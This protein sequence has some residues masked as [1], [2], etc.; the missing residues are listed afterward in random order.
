MLPVHRWPEFLSRYVWAMLAPHRAAK[1]ANR[2][3]E[4]QFAI[5][6]GM[7]TEVQSLRGECERLRNQNTEQSRALLT[8][9]Q[10][11]EA[12]SKQSLELSLKDAA[13]ISD[14]SERLESTEDRASNAEAERVR[15]SEQLSAEQARHAETQQNLDREKAKSEVLTDQMMLLVQ[16]RETELKR[17]EAEAVIHA[18]R[19]SKATGE[20]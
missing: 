2:R 17:L 4:R 3:L 20:E 7:N 5:N 12:Q 19:G 6:R 1:D 8:E 18:K 13:A 14:L 16:W 15:L 9:M 10:G 11:R